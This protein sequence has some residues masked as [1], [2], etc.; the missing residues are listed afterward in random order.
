MK[1]LIYVS[2]AAH[3]MSGEELGRIMKYS[4][5]RNDREEITGLL[6]YRFFPDEGRGNFMQLLEGGASAVEAAWSRIAADRRHHTKIRLEEGEIDVRAFPHWSMGFRNVAEA[7]LTSFEGY[8]D[9]GSTQFWDRA[10][11]GALPGA[12]GTMTSF[13]EEN[14]QSGEA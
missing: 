12:L 2:Q 5:T 13:Y 6:I 1:Y 10:R 14:D 3:P 4:R 8:T 7:D 9:L 11:A